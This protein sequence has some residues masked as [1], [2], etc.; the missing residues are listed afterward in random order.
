MD[1]QAVA[2][3]TRRRH[4]RVEAGKRRLPENLAG[5]RSKKASYSAEARTVEAA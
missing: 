4:C 3:L 1:D 5:V 2:A